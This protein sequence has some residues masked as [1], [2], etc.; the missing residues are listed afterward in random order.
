MSAEDFL[1]GRI[2]TLTS[3]DLDPVNASAFHA[4]TQAMNLKRE[5]RL[6]EA[7]EI[8]EKACRPPTIYKGQYHALFV[9]WRHFN[10][11]DM[12]ALH[13]KTVIH[14][15]LKMIK[16][17]QQMIAKMLK[18]W[19]SVQGRKLPVGYFDCDRNLRPTD[20]KALLKAAK[21]VGDVDAKRIAQGAVV[22]G[23]RKSGRQ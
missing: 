2:N 1:S 18:H 4:Y 22:R 21:E 16:H 17:D 15:V 9:I 12:A 8:L 23:D 10:R 20:L 3:R 5:G 7:A 11:D 14:R 13:Y 6:V 19:G